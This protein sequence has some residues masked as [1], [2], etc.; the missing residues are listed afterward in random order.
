MPGGAVAR[1]RAVHHPLVVTRRVPSW[2]VTQPECVSPTE[3]K[4][5]KPF[6]ATT[7]K[8]FEMGPAEWAR[9]LRA[10]L[11]DPSRV[12]VIDSNISTVIAEADKVLWVGEPDPWIEHVEFQA[13]RDSGLPDR[14]HHYST[15]LRRAHGVPVHSTILLLRPAAD[16]PELTGKYEQ[17][18]SDGDVYDV[19]QY[20][21]LRIWQQPVEAIL[22]A[23]LP[24]LP[25][26][27]VARVELDQVRGVLEVI[28]RR[29]HTETTSDDQAAI[30]WTATKM[31]MGLR[32]PKDR[33][34]E[35]TRGIS[36]MILGIRGIEESSV[37]Q[38]ILEKG[39][40]KAD[41]AALLRLGR[42][43]F[44]PPD[45]TVEATIDALVDLDRLNALLDR[46]L[47][48]STWDELLATP[49]ADASNGA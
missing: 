12:S 1:C 23:G 13:G 8:L 44:G 14:V 45:E 38:D 39:Q 3:E 20:D 15:N 7:R 19:F 18:Y 11:T 22:A 32:Y 21:V 35:L 17:R 16:G 33:V 48:V 43:K 4:M 2:M 49:G 5:P 27:P 34:E 29:F 28:S 36:D 10:R 46:I 41:R 31:L 37:Y 30:L 25:L 9:F 24:V 47:D 40:F 6:D 26:A 42:K